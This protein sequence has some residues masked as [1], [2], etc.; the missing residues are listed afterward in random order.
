MNLTTKRLVLIP[1]AKKHV[2]A[3]YKLIKEDN[4]ELSRWTTIQYPITKEKIRKFYHH[5]KKEKDHQTF[6]ILEKTTKE[7]LGSIGLKKNIANNSAGI[8]YWIGKQ[9]RNKGYITEAVKRVIA[10]AFQKK[11]VVRVEIHAM[12]ENKRSLRVIKKAGL[13]YEGTLR[14]AVR[15]GLKQYGDSAVY[16]ILKREWKKNSQ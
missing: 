1:A 13:K 3:V 2:D 12:G 7:V 5:T 15:N 16:S 4:K 11:K 14:Q 9:F 10:Y 8:G 6:I